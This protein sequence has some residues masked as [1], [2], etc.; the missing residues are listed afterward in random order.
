MDPNIRVGDFER[1]EAIRRL[2]THHSAGRITIE[3]FD[4]R[5][6]R[7]LDAKTAGDLTAIFDDLP[8]APFDQ[9]ATQPAGPPAPAPV[10]YGPVLSVEAHQPQPFVRSPWFFWAI[11]MLVLM[12]GFRI[13]PLL[14]G[15]AVWSWVIVP[16]TSNRHM[17]GTGP[18]RFYYREGDLEGEIQALL[19]A[20]RKVEAIKRW[21]ERTGVGLAEAKAA[22]EAIERG[23]RGLGR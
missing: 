11:F 19:L 14:V 10:Q 4:D 23:E 20:G 8:D 9:P 5:V 15:V 21:R 7:A 6:A 2:T 22:V 3:E 12:T 17:I 13:W 1:D 16:A 18:E